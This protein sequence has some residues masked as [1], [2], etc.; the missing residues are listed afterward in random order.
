MNKLLDRNFHWFK[1]HYDEFC[2]KYD[3]KFVIV[4]N[5]RIVDYDKTFSDALRRA[6]FKGFKPGTYL[7]QECLKDRKA[8]IMDAFPQI[9]LPWTNRKFLSF[10]PRSGKG[11][12]EPFG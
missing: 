5:C 1:E 2:E 4:K 9:C 10:P 8:Y 11:I 3:K 12:F 6:E 7:V